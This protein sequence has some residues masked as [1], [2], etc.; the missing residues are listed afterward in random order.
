[1]RVAGARHVSK[2]P[3]RASLLNNLRHDKSSTKINME[4]KPRSCQRRGA[5]AMLT[6]GPPGR[7]RW[8]VAGQTHAPGPCLFL[9]KNPY[10]KS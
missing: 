10:I 6:Q 2:G 3:G 9:N 5:Q 7:Q 8:H 4:I 1:M